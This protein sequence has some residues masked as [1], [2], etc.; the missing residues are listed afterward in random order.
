MVANN[1]TY[2]VSKNKHTTT[3]DKNK[4]VHSQIKIHLKNITE[5][6]KDKKLNSTG[7]KADGK[8]NR[9]KGK[10]NRG[11]TKQHNYTLFNQ[12]IKIYKSIKRSNKSNT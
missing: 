12:T 4:Q 11:K 6:E 3:K 2:R 7:H 9:R 1:N 8:L 5:I 10:L